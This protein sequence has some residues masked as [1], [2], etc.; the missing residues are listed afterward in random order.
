MM[1]TIGLAMNLRPGAEEPYQRAHDQLWP[2][3]ANG[4]RAQQISMAIYQDGLRLFLFAAAPS[5]AHWK[6]SRED[7]ILEKWDARMTEHLETDAQGRIAFTLL[8]KAFG[9]GKFA[10]Q[11]V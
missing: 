3:L 1:F 11:I 5:E 9:F 10:D 2:D 8:P 6:R 7:P 4:M